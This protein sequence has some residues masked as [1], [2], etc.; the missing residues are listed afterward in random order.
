MGINI[1]TSAF[2]D[3]QPS[4]I[5]S[6]PDILRTIQPGGIYPCADFLGSLTA[7]NIV[8]TYKAQ[9]YYPNVYYVNNDGPNGM[10]VVGGAPPPSTGRAPAGPFVAR[11]NPIAGE[12]V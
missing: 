2:N 12:Q 9:G 3:G 4:I 1:L 11:I 8:Y 7:P 5:R 10:Y 6:G